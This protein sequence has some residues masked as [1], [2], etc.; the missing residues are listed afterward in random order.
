M[1]LANSVRGLLALSLGLWPALGCNASSEDLGSAGDEED[2]AAAEDGPGDAGDD[3]DDDDAPD[4]ES[5]ER[6]DGD[7][8]GDGDPGEGPPSA[9]RPLPAVAGGTLLV[10][11]D[12]GHAVASDPDRDLIHVFDIGVS[13][14][15]ASIASSL[16]DLASAP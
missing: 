11:R 9:G 4:S 6:G 16:D 13:R 3:D 7:G 1:E 15:A 10:T 2:P 5:P 8:G 14:H 12:G